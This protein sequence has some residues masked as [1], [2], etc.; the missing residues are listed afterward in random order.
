M[1]AEISSF[2][3]IFHILPVIP[4]YLVISTVTISVTK[5]FMLNEKCSPF[6]KIIFG[7]IFYLF[8]IMVLVTHTLSMWTSPGYVE[9]GYKNK[10]NSNDPNVSQGHLFC[11]KCRNERPPRAHHCKSCKKC[12]LKMDHHC[13]WIANCVGFR[14]QKFF[15]Q[16][17]FY[18]TFGDLLGFFLIISHLF[19]GLESNAIDSNKNQNK[20]FDSVWDIVWQ[21]WTPIMIVIS[22]TVAMAMTLAIGLLFVIQTK[23]I[24]YN[25]TTVE[26]HIFSDYSLNP[27]YYEDKLHNFQIVMGNTFIEWFLPIFKANK[28]NNGY[29]FYTPKN[30]SFSDLSNKNN[31]NYLQ[32]GAD[33]ELQEG[34]QDVISS[35]N[36]T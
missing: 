2:T 30:V 32:L 27:W 4:V 34:S 18:A 33:L 36:R 26:T 3:K 17:L 8:S 22:A 1:Y 11:K 19:N 29:Y 5:Y 13:P 14:N 28:F 15:Y 10:S 24:L 7:G 12:T 6:P 25:Q 20:Q 23:M 21:M 35:S 9:Y 16:F 31:I